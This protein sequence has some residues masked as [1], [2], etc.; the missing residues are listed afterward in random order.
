MLPMLQFLQSS[1]NGSEVVEVGSF[2]LKQELPHGTSPRFRFIELYAE[3]HGRATSILVCPE[4]RENREW[5]PMHANDGG[6][7]ASMV[8][9]NREAVRWPPLCT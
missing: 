5:T 9:R 8:A 7:H 6:G 4:K 1:R 2:Q 3:I